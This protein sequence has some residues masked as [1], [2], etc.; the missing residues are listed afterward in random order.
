MLDSRQFLGLRLIGGFVIRDIAFSDA[1]FL[2]AIGREAIA[3]TTIHGLDLWMLIRA[4]LSEEEL[5]ISLYH[6][7]LEAVSVGSASPPESVMDFNEAAFE[8]AAQEA[9]GRWGM[10]SPKNLNLMLQF[11]GFGEE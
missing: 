3:Q 6:E 8:K 4:G 2:D 11:H 5:S 9:H 1:P 7:V 10:A